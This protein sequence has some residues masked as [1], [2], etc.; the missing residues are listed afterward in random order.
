LN[1]T[2]FKDD[3]EQYTDPERERKA[4]RR[5]KILS[6]LNCLVSRYECL[7]KTWNT[8]IMT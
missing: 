3:D 4:L 8:A 5:R 6:K 1:L 7:I 2:A